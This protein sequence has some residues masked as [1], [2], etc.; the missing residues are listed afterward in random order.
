MVLTD[1]VHEFLDSEIRVT[2]H[3]ATYAEYELLITFEYHP[4]HNEK[5]EKAFPLHDNRSMYHHVDEVY[6]E[7]FLSYRPWWSTHENKSIIMLADAPYKDVV[8]YVDLDDYPKS[9]Q[10]DWMARNGMFTLQPWNPGYSEAN[11]LFGTYYIRV[12]PDYNLA[13]LVVDTKRNYSYLFRAFS[14][15]AGGEHT[16]L[17][18]GSNVA[19]VA[20]SS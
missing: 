14:Q 20:Y 4:T 2:V 8:F 5:L 11:G 18:G 19:G 15:P 16:D 17:Y 3:G 1:T 13:D 6:D 7:A 9:Y 10:T 12:R